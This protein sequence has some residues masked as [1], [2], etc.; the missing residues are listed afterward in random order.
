MPAVLEAARLVAHG[1]DS[2]MEGFAI[3]PAIGTY[4]TVEPVSS[5][6]ISGAFEEDSTRQAFE[7]FDEFMRRHDVP[8]TLAEPA[9][10]FL[11]LAARRSGR[12]RLPR[13][14]WPRVR[15][16]RA[17]PARA[18]SVQ[19]AH[20]AA[21]SRAVRKRPAGAD[22]AAR[23]AGQ[24]RPQHSDCLERQ[25]RTGAHQHLRHAVPARGREG[26]R[27]HGGGRNHA[28]AF[29]RTGRAASAPQ[30]DQGGSG[31]GCH[32]RPFHR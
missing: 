24:H 26:D 12:R 9:Q 30:R 7:L 25:H 27:A 4:V 22:R 6:A 19:S 20:G 10:L 18:R 28:R 11:R 16:D 23:G 1:F 32:R 13:Q 8:R 3:R 5:L 29:R 21:R 15:S 14:L 17:R 31:D 2:Y